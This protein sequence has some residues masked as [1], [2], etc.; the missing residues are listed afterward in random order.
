MR[1]AGVLRGEEPIE[2]ENLL[3]RYSLGWKEFE[4]LYVSQEAK[5]SPHL[6]RGCARG[7]ICH[8]NDVRAGSHLSES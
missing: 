2:T 7:N 6:F 1:P 3:H 5:E 4:L 8:L